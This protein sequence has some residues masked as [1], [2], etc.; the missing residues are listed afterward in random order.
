M[1]P[2]IH[3]QTLRV[4]RVVALA[5]Y[6][7]ELDKRGI[8]ARQVSMDS[9][10]PGDILQY[11]NALLSV[12]KAFAF[13]DRACQAANDRH[14]G[15]TVG[16]AAPLAVLG[17]YGRIMHCMPTVGDYLIE[18]VRLYNLLTNGQSL[19]IVTGADTWRIQV[20]WSVG[21]ETGQYQSHL[22]ILAVIINR[23]RQA[24]GRNWCPPAI[25]LPLGQFV[26]IPESDL[27]AG[28]R[29]EQ[30]GL[31]SWID[32]PVDILKL[33]L[34]CDD[35]D[36][37]KLSPGN[38]T[39]QLSGDLVDCVRTQIVELIARPDLAVDLVAECLNLSRRT[40]QRSLEQRDVCFSGLLLAVRREMAMECLRTT[41][42]P[43]IEI[44]LDLGYT[45]ASNFTRAFR[46][47]NGLSPQ[48]FR[49]A[50]GRA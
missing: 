5:P 44:A 41:D 40:L 31:G 9:G 39:R 24:A 29:L 20:G 47:A 8:D 7:H 48:C 43:I 6:I 26:A 22:E 11:P 28:T 46:K 4:A 38:S 3:K 30:C 45:D 17:D 36:P 37:R 14:F 18:G 23:C 21:P 50:L 16:Q 42:K 49:T 32:I 13:V 34:P 10:L 27:F 2:V 25:S 19:G 15:L 33:G 12:E 35:N 1:N